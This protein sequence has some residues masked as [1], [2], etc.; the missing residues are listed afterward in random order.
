MVPLLPPPPASSAAATFPL[1]TL[2]LFPPTLSTTIVGTK[3]I[4]GAAVEGEEQGGE[5]Y[6]HSKERGLRQATSAVT[7]RRDRDR[8]RG[9][10]AEK[11]NLPFR[12]VWRKVFICLTPRPYTQTRTH[13][14]HARHA[15]ART[16]T[17]T[18]TGTHTHTDA[19]TGTNL[20]MSVASR[21]HVFLYTAA[22]CTL[23]VD[24]SKR[25]LPFCVCVCV[26]ELE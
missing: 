19:D 15:R 12:S 13:T 6:N 9:R 24:Y 17:Q 14:T 7:R 23:R 25:A 4:G 18:H 22:Q 26:S 2:Q 20:P 8:D 1:F 16:H 3:R 10:H 21:F 5:S 11:R